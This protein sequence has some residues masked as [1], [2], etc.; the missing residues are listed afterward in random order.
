MLDN[1]RASLAEELDRAEI[2]ECQSW[3]KEQP[4][5]VGGP[6]PDARILVWV[7]TEA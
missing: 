2:Y 7:P 6:D 5:R 4:G 3:T 1:Y